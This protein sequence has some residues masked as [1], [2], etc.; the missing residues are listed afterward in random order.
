MKKH[1][2]QEKFLEELMKTPIVQ[3]ACERVGISRNTYY[4]WIK[5]DVDFS[6]AVEGCLGVGVGFVN[7]HAESNI[8]NGIKK[9]E[10]RATTYWL[11][12][13][14]REFRRPFIIKNDKDLLEE[15]HRLEMLQAEKEVGKWVDGWITGEKDRLEEKA[16]KLF[17][18][19][20]KDELKKKKSEKLTPT[21]DT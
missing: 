18:T 11:S 19:W 3:H 16:T 14:H 8:L 2:L 13:R 1:R 10:M 5:E 4:R 21:L 7:D 9:G 17:E 6:L 20:K 15:N 12:H